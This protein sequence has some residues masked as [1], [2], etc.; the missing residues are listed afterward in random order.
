MGARGTYQFPSTP[1]AST[2]VTVTCAKAG[3][4]KSSAFGKEALLFDRG[5]SKGGPLDLA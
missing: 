1:S 3:E 5:E 4:A 2:G